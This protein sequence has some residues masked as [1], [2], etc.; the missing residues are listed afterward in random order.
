[1]NRLNELAAHGEHEHAGK[2]PA[3]E[4]KQRGLTANRV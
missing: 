2:L 4:G 1:M 3:A